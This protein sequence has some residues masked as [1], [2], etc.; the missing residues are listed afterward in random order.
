MSDPIALMQLTNCLARLAVWGLAVGH[1]AVALWELALWLLAFWEFGR[2]KLALG[3]LAR[4][5]D[6]YFC[7]RRTC[8]RIGVPTKPNDSRSRFTRNRS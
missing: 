8:R 2:W 4:D 7:L 5:R 6:R 3:A 1:L